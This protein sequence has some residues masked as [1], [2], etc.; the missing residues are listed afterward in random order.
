M[1][2]QF[3]QNEILKT[4]KDER[5]TVTVILMNGFRIEK[6]IIRDFDDYSIM[7]LSADNLQLLY[8]HAIST[9]ILPKKL[10][11]KKD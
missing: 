8:K 6:A 3:M 1:R 5:H 10:N 9:I 4:L 2:K 11:R 7:L